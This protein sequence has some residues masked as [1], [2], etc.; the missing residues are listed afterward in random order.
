MLPA[1]ALHSRLEQFRSNMREKEA[2]VQEPSGMDV[3][4]EPPQVWCFSVR[5]LWPGQMSSELLSHL[6]C[7]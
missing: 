7:L 2:D 3:D 5:L 4:V 1:R 6:A